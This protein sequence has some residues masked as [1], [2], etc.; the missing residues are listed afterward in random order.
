M[1]VI[2]IES[3]AFYALIEEVIAR[4]QK[5]EKNKWIDERT[6]M[7]L[8]GIRS[9]TSLWKLRSSGKIRFSQPTR[10][11]I[12]YEHESILNYLEKHAKEI[13]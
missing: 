5:P 9:K 3:Q 7:E 11:L 13:F 1:E 8:L 4:S 2:T 12:R 6:A 10:K